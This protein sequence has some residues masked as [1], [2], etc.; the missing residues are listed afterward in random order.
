MSLADLRDLVIVIT[1]VVNT[2]VL[3]GL[4]VIVFSAYKRMKVVLE[5]AAEA[6]STLHQIAT[7]IHGAIR[8]IDIVSKIINKIG[9]GKE[10]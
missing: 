10:K 7:V 2:A 3:I 9:G 1:A 8:G 5:A 4:F 6:S